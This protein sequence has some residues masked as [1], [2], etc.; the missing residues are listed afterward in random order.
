MCKYIG[1]IRTFMFLMHLFYFTLIILTIIVAF[2][3]QTI[4]LLEYEV[5]KS[6]FFVDSKIKKTPKGTSYSL[7]F[8]IRTQ[9]SFL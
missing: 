5:P 9:K 8:Y 4:N 6:Y 7:G 3:Q 1:F 2:L